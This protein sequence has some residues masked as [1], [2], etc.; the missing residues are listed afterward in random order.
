MRRALLYGLIAGVATVVNI[1]QAGA[2]PADDCH[3]VA[4]IGVAHMS[5]DRV[6]TLRLRSLPPGPI[7]EGEFRYA[8]KDPQY[9][10][11]IRHLGGIRPGEWKPVRP[12]C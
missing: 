8:P 12:W 10:D 7:A 5:E 9:R 1:V 2:E 4:S 3:S 11:V 6:I